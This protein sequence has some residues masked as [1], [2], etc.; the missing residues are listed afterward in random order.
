LLEDQHRDD[1][2]KEMGIRVKNYSDKEVLTEINEV[3]EDIY[4]LL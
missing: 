3:L 2:F 1:Y 4:R